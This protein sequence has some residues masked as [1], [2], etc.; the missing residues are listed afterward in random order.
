MLIRAVVRRLMLRGL[1]EPGDHVL[2]VQLLGDTAAHHV[3]VP[4][5]GERVE[6]DAAGL[7]HGRDQPVGHVR[8][9][10]ADH[11]PEGRVLGARPETH[12]SQLLGKT[13]VQGKRKTRCT[14]RLSWA[15]GRS[16]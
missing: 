10:T 6:V 13:S 7:L 16:R 4:N 5:A 1:A 11:V 14:C 8:D 12:R 9:Q 2:P 15:T 3:P